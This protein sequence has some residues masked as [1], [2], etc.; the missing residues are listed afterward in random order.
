MGGTVHKLAKIDVADCH[1]LRQLALKELIMETLHRQPGCKLDIDVARLC[2]D[3]QALC[4]GP[5]GRHMQAAGSIHFLFDT[6]GTLL[7]AAQGLLGTRP[8]LKMLSV[9][10]ASFH[11]VWGDDDP[12]KSEAQSL[13]MPFM[14]IQICK[15]GPGVQSEG[16][17]L[18]G[19]RH[20]V[21]S[22]RGPANFG[23]A[24]HGHLD[25]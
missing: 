14:P 18:G 7:E 21:C 6:G 19:H 2:N 3:L 5:L 12:G 20:E 11:P 25:G 8:A 4:G 23:G 24:G 17:H 16:D 10:W 9:S 1:Q 13:L 15:C 22:P